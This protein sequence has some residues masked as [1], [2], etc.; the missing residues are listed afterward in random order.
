MIHGAAGCTVRAVL[1]A[2]NN[3]LMLE[4]IVCAQYSMS[5]SVTRFCTSTCIVILH[6]IQYN[7]PE[8]YITPQSCKCI[9]FYA[10]V[11]CSAPQYP[12]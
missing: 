12:L 3:G 5:C 7:D 4:Q 11:D 9:Y 2:E 1:G 10:C 6:T 8:V